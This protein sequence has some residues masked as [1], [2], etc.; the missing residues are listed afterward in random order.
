MGVPDRKKLDENGNIDRFKAQLVANGMRQLDGFDVEET[1]AP[2]IKPP[3]VKII[4]SLVVTWGW[5]LRQFDVSN[6]FL[7]D[8]LKEKVYMNQ[9]SGYKDPN[10]P[11]AVCKL[12]RSIYG[13]RQSP[14]AW[15]HRLGDFIIAFG[16][17]ESKSYQSLFMYIHN[18]INAYF[19][20]KDIHRPVCNKNQQ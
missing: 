6:A 16:F 13:L 20:L 15:F 1:F 19:F 5:K 9:S 18:D 2:V 10:K 12:L 4:L 3:M 11:N 8:I 7:H 14:R 17:T